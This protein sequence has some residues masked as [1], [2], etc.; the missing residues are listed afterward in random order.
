M[1]INKVVQVVQVA[2]PQVYH[3][4]HTRH[5]RK[6]SSVHRVSARDSTILAHLN[7]TSPTVPARLAEHLGIARSTLSEA[8]KR[9]TALGY[10]EPPKTKSGGV[11][12][13]SKG[14]EVIR[15]NSVL[16][17]RRLEDVLRTLTVAERRAVVAGMQA[18]ADGCQRMTSARTGATRQT[19]N[20]DSE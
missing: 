19:R 16:E 2:Y 20:P 10:V 6:R 17:E 7:T 1:D 14:L 5:Q 3:A 11:R 4:C 12:L 8:L 15:S 9:L 18:L 13:S